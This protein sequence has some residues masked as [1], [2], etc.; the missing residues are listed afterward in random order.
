MCT[1]GD[2]S[3]YTD[4]AYHWPQAKTNTRVDACVQ[5]IVVCAC[6]ILSVA[7]RSHFEFLPLLFKLSHLDDDDD[8]TF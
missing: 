6:C 3:M 4:V 8:D 1:S 2:G 5:S 7:H